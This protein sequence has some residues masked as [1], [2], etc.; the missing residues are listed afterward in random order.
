MAGSSTQGSSGLLLPPTPGVTPD[1]SGPRSSP[2]APAS[3]A[4]ASTP[5]SSGP[6]SSPAAPASAAGADEPVPRDRKL[7][8]LKNYVLKKL[9]PRLNESYTYLSRA[10][11]GIIKAHNLSTLEPY[12]DELQDERVLLQKHTHTHTHTLLLRLLLPLLHILHPSSR[13]LSANSSPRAAA[14]EAR[15]RHRKLLQMSW[16]RGRAR[17]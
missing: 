12:C 10:Q 17:R 13:R 2:A 9:P 3:A 5:G 8:K 7:R 16:G 15:T 1:S 6:R 14:R 4:G 11:V